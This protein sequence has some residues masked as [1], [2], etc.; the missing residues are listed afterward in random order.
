M[1]L[2]AFI[3]AHWQIITTL[4]AAVF[5]FGVLVQQGRALKA[6]H[7]EGLASIRAALVAHGKALKAVAQQAHEDNE[8]LRQIVLHHHHDEVGSVRVGAKALE[9][10][11]A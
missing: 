4:V 11:G 1:D 6:A 7:A 9:S 2:V 8:S 10:R 5:G 3:E